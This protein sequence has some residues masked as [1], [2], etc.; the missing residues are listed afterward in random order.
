M[1]K[2]VWIATLEAVGHWVEKH[3]GTAGWMQAGGAILAL[4]TAIYVPWRQRR[5]QI[6]DKKSCLPKGNRNRAVTL[7]TCGHHAG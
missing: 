7:G 5:N 3:P 6:G 4:G 2:G 1:I